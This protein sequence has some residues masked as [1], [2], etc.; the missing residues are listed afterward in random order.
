MRK[1]LYCCMIAF[2]LCFYGLAYGSGKEESPILPAS[3]FDNDVAF[4]KKYGD[5]I[6]L[7]DPSGQS[8]IAV[9]P[10]LQGR[11]M[12]STAGAPSKLSYGW[13]N[14]PLFEAGE[15]SEH[16]NAFGGEE[17]IWLG[18]EGGQF[19]IFFAAGSAFTRENWYTPRFVDVEPWDVVNQTEQS[20]LFTKEATLTNYSGATFE[21]KLNREVRVLD[22][23]AALSAIGVPED[24]RLTSVAYQ[25][26]NDLQNAGQEP[27]DRKTGLLMIWLLGRF[28]PS[29]DTTIVVPFE[30][31]PVERIGPVVNDNYYSKV[32]ADRL[33]IADGTVFFRGDGDHRSKIGMTAERAKGV[34]GSYDAS[35]RTLTIIKYTTGLPEDLYVN[36]KWEIQD[37]PYSGGDVVNAYNGGPSASGARTVAPFYELESS[38]PARELKP[39]ER[40]RYI[41]TT[42]HFQGDDQALDALAKAALGVSLDQ[43]TEAFGG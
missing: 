15:I 22:N 21:I 18:P 7:K 16:T 3:A 9:M 42:S 30:A 13:I 4:L 1:H 14:R 25:T 43:I 41:Q 28:N 19:S 32:P 33:K 8:R 17:R 36:Q 24:A 23:R 29:P 38:S 6:V 34:M 35:N 12:T 31:G 10:T 20:A 11:V 40:M 37:L 2:S 26:V 5:V 27:W 39:G